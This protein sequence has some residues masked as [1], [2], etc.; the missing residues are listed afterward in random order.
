MTSRASRWA[1]AAL[2]AIG[3]WSGIACGEGRPP[4][5]LLLV[6]VDTLRASELGA[7]GGDRGLTPHLDALARQAIVFTNVYAPASLTLPSIGT[8]LTGRYPEELGIRTNES[9][10]PDSVSTLATELA[11]RGWRTASVVGNFV[12][13]RASGVARG[14]DVFD[15]RFSTHERVRRWPERA[16]EDTTDAALD[17]LAECTAQGSVPC[18]LWVHYQDPHGPYTP[19][20]GRREALLEAE[21]QA[22]DGARRLPAGDD[23]FGFG[24]IPRYQFLDGRHDVAF[25]RA[26]YRAEVRYADEQIGRLLAGVRERGLWDDALVVFAADHGESLGEGDVWFAHGSRLSDEQVRVPLLIRIPGRPAGRRGDLVSLID[27]Y[28]TLLALVTHE[29]PDET[30]LGRDLLQPGAESSGSRPYLST[31]GGAETLRFALVEDGFKFVATQRGAVFD[32][33][34]HRLGHEDVDLTAAAPQLAARMRG[35]LDALRARIDRGASET[36]QTL[37]ERD[38]ELLRGLGYLETGGAGA[39]EP[40]TGAAPAAPPPR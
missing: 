19:P 14:F 35:D 34:L 27:V 2:C 31:L 3:C 7:Y 30:R 13:R 29:P 8:L 24:S 22:A 33:A 18:L 21:Q 11:R 32:G 5:L 16:A 10:L 23:H 28:P 20:A 25:Y 12:L 38:R 1:V 6:T 9:G 17:V 39:D 4:R 40:L 26:G 36:P 15:D 37:S